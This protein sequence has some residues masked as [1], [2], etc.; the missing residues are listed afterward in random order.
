MGFVKVELPFEGLN[1][2]DCIMEESTNDYDADGAENDYC[3]M[4][5]QMKFKLQRCKCCVENELREV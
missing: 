5:D 4:F 2:N 1:C 3:L